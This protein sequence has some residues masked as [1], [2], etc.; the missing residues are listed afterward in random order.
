MRLASPGFSLVHVEGKVGDFFNEHFSQQLVLQGV[1]VTTKNEISSLLGFERQK[2]LLG[3]SDDSASCLAEMAGALGVDGLITGSLARFGS[4]Y[5]INLKIVSAK[6]GTVL[7]AYA[8][9]L[10]GDEAMLDWLTETAK[11]FASKNGQHPD[12]VAK[13]T[14]PAPKPEPAP[15]EEPATSFTEAS[16]PEVE[17]SPGRSALWLIPAG[18]GVALL[19]GGVIGLVSSA[20]QVDSIM[21]SDNISPADLSRKSE[22]AVKMQQTGT[23]LLSVGVAVAG[24]TGLLFAL[25]GSDDPPPV[26]LAVHPGGATLVWKGVLP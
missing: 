4:S 10:K 13:A 17:T 12:V 16:S 26:T 2:A 3:C 23:I 18:A 25:T 1:R 15:S 7:G 20:G 21:K 5:A 9:R 24:A 6:N 8:T 14:E 11:R 22:S 19:A